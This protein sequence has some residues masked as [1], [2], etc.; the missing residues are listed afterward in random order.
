MKKILLYITVLAVVFSACE[1]D[2]FDYQPYTPSVSEID[3]L[4]FSTGAKTLVADGKAAL[5]FVVE[6][7]RTAQFT[8]ADGQQFDSI[9][10]VNLRHLPEGAIKITDEA[11]NTLGQEFSTTDLGTGTKEFKASI[12]DVVSEIKSVTLRQAPPAYEKLYVDVIF[13]VFELKSSD[14]SYDPLT[15]REI[16]QSHLERAVED[17]NMV[18]NNQ[19]GNGPNAGSTNIEFR[20]AAKD[21]FNRVM[22]RPGYKRRD[23]DQSIAARSSISTTDFIAVM[24]ANNGRNIWTPTKFLNIVVIPGGSANSVRT[25]TPRNQ[26]VT[27]G[28]PSLPGMGT[29]VAPGSS[30]TKNYRNTCA[31]VPRALMFPGEDARLIV[32][33]YVGKFYGLFGTR[34]TNGIPPFVPPYRNDYCTD[35]QN[36]FLD[37]GEGNQSNLLLKTDVNGDK[38]FSE[39]LMDDLG[40]NF[41]S[42]R[43]H[44]TIDQAE[45][46]RYAI[47][48]CPGRNNGLTE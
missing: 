4:Y 31:A 25:S 13:H 41:P 47:E 21:N 20:L 38:F 1:E 18:F 17:L 44:V 34:F 37:A 5:K 14:P 36:F 15:H 28:D 7:Y 10:Q 6:A 23:Y 19:L 39:N 33:G 46:V 29:P 12:G 3:S 27:S 43:N 30:I 2:T 16:E 32:S 11:D 42:F 8:N 9:V 45:R 26:F 22:S 24:D 35:T 40:L 48:N